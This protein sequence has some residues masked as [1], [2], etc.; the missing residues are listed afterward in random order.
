M[1]YIF[2]LLVII[3]SFNFAIAQ[4][5]VIC[6]DMDR[7]QEMES[8]HHH[9]LLN[10]KRNPYTL[11][12]DMKYHRFELDVDPSKYYINGKV[13]SYFVPTIEGFQKINFEFLDNMVINEISY[14][15][16]LLNHEFIDGSILE[17]VLPAV[18]AEGVLDSITIDYKGAPK[19]DG[20]GSFEVNVHSGTPVMWT[21][22]EPYGAKAWWPCKQDL[23]DKIDSI[24]MYIKTPVGN[25]AA[26][27]GVLVSEIED[28]NKIVYHWKHRH[29]IPAYLIAFAV[30]NYSVFSDYVYLDNG[31]S[32]EVL[33]YVYPEHLSQAK[34]KRSNI[35]DIIEFYNEKFGLYPF[36]DEKY[37]HAEF[38]WGGGMEHQT[39]SFMGSF[40]YSLQAHELAHQWF[41]DKITCGSWE[42]I[43]L[44]EGFATYLTGLTNEFLKS[45]EAWYDWKNYQVTRITSNNGG[46]VWVNDTTS[47]NRIFNSRLT[48]SKGSYL[49]H[50]LR[51]IVGDE[52]FFQGCR[53]YLADPKLAY[54][55]A[56]TSDLQRHLEALGDIDLT[57]F[58]NDWFYGQGYP[59]YQ[60]KWTKLDNGISINLSQTSSHFSVDF[61]EM[62]VPI[63]VSGEGQDSML[64]LNHTFSG[65]DFV[66]ELPFVVENVVFDP[67]L[68]LISKSNTV[69]LDV[70][71]VELLKLLSSEIEVKPNPIRDV[72]NV[73]LLNL[74]KLDIDKIEVIDMYGR[75]IE[76]VEPNNPSAILNTENWTTG[77]Y[78]LKLH[79][80]NRVGVKMVIKG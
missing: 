15:G 56:K 67:E 35:V 3:G 9:Q 79:A 59:S 39:M 47:V 77:C 34:S 30:T 16:E 64:I 1:K 63:F 43:W 20:F 6:K 19:S 78:V 2:Q 37:G 7:I 73:K 18:I 68:A 51:G 5:E 38:G 49:L 44:N 23:N 65:E 27:N 21:L 11:D 26:S 75:I 17:I 33:N 29:P 57:E 74:N 22:S 60:V 70:T 50:M 62:P 55:Y 42:D 80:K 66:F 61:F 46:S 72:L 10:H 58:F 12:Y 71:E 13:T 24:D 54:G 40:S 8:M 45:E 25:R 31:D 52:N 48:Y 53:N 28:G 76:I 69:I 41:G 4:D 32:I 14:H 36:A